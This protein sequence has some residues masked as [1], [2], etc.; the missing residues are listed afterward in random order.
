MSTGVAGVAIDLSARGGFGWSCHCGGDSLALL[1]GT[2]ADFTVRCGCGSIYRARLEQ[3]TPAQHK[4]LTEALERGQGV[5]PSEWTASMGPERPG[6]MP[7]AT[8][9]S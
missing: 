9:G 6:S 1:R 3:W 8:G 2:A 7:P 4:E 5:T